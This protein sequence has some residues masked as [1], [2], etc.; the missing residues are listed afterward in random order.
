[1]NRGRIDHALKQLKA[2]KGRPGTLPAKWLYFRR[3]IELR[4]A[5]AG[6]VV[7]AVRPVPKEQ[8]TDPVR[9]WGAFPPGWRPTENPGQVLF[10]AAT[11]Q[12]YWFCAVPRS[13]FK[14]YTQI[15]ELEARK[16]Y[17]GLAAQP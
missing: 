7:Y 13:Q 2:T 8:R 11:A 3:N 12:Q 6:C 14:H 16:L 1:M 17:P 10:D 4:E 15:T 5:S 9:A